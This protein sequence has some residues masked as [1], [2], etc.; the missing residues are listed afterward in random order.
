MEKFQA[1]E[2]RE[3]ALKLIDAGHLFLC[4]MESETRHG[5]I[6]HIFLNSKKLQADLTT[7]LPER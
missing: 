2:S 3:L 5:V 4:K 6:Y 7:Y 1:V